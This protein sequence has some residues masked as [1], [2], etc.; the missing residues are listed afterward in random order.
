MDCNKDPI[1]EIEGLRKNYGEFQ[2]RIPKLSIY[3][4][5]YIGLIGENGAGK[6]TLI[7]LILNLVEK[8]EGVIKLFKKPVLNSSLKKEI[9]VVFDQCYY[10]GLLCV[11]ELNAILK[12]VYKSKWNEDQFIRDAKNHALPLKQPIATLSQGMKAKLNLISTFAHSPRLILLDEATN[13]LDPVVRREINEEIKNYTYQTGCTVL[14]S[15]HLVNELELLCNRMFFMNKGSILLETSPEE[16]K[17]SYY[18]VDLEKNT[19]IPKE[20]LA[21]IPNK[22]YISCLTYGIPSGIDSSLVQRGVSTDDLMYFLTRGEKV[23]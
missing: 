1:I 15:S 23:Q 5:E 19:A 6:S 13:N 18:T 21:V 12:Y 20:T 16:L 22:K 8:D 10:S 4:G 14:F 3:Q 11:Q 7:K 9:G 2:L 17:T